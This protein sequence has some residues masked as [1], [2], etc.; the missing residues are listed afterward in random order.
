MLGVFGRDLAGVWGGFRYLVVCA[1]V[2]LGAGAFTTLLGLVWSDVYLTP[3]LSIWPL[4]DALIVAWALLFPNRA[5]L[6]MLVMPAAGRNLLY[7]TLGMTTL[8]AVMYGFSNFAPHFAAMT[9]M[10]AYV[11]GGTLIATELRL[12]RLLGQKRDTRGF[13]VV[14]GGRDTG[15]GR[16]PNDSGWVH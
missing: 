4:A 16:R 15:T 8:F 12:N 9:L 10:Y 14:D 7:L 3:Y 2:A 11:R 6:F 1:G 13:R 5:I